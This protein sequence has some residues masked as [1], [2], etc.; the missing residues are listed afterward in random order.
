MQIIESKIEIRKNQIKLKIDQ[1][2]DS[3]IKLR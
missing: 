3:N 2:R 1:H